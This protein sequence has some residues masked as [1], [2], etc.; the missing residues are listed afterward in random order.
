MKKGF[1]SANA[2][3]GVLIALAIIFFILPGIELEVLGIRAKPFGFLLGWSWS[4]IIINA[5]GLAIYIFLATIFLFVHF[6]IFA[7]IHNAELLD[8]FYKNV[9]SMKQKDI[10][11]ISAI[12]KKITI[13]KLKLAVRKKKKKRVRPKLIRE[14]IIK[15]R[16]RRIP[17]P[18]P[19]ETEDI[20]AELDIP[21]L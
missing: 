12:T 1:I 16:G 7:F 20:I 17:E 14:T 21:S 3:L 18:E 2:I 6:R 11:R 9:L 8:D 15:E 13:K 4:G 19:E 10:N 5:I